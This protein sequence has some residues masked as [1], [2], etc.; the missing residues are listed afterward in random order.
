MRTNATNLQVVGSGPFIKIGILLCEGYKFKG[1][2]LSNDV[3]YVVDG[4]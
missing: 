2:K 3:T 1:V 4:I